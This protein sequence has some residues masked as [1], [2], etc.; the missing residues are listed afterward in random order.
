[1]LSRDRA[2]EKEQGN[3]RRK[4]IGTVQSSIILVNGISKSNTRLQHADD[5]PYN[6]KCPV[7]LPK[8]NH[9]TRL[10]IKYYHELKDHQMRLNYTIN[11]VREKYL[12][13]HV[14]KQVKR[15]IMR[16]CFECARR[17]RSKLAHQQMA[18]LPKIRLQQTS[19]PFESCTVD[20]GGPFLT[21]QGRGRF[22]FF[23]LF[24][25]PWCHLDMVSSLDTDT[26]LNAFVRMTAR[27]GWSQQMLIDFGT[28]FV[29]ASRELQ[30]LVPAMDQDKIL[31]MTS[32][33]GMSWK[34]NQPAAPHFGGVFESMIK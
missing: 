12:E 31:R 32:N 21:K 3:T 25:D 24:E 18:L 20:F 13:V 34:W 11:H 17:F 33:K 19:R 28:K 29:S 7:I 4:Y 6:V 5:L 1:M 30:G 14:S 9:V 22:V 15:V 2:I 23:S 26:F 27:R 8:R 16:Q 10:I